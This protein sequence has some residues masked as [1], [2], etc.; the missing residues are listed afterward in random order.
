MENFLNNGTV[1][2]HG[3]M[4]HG[5]ED[6]MRGFNRTYQNT[7]LRVGMIAASYA[8]SDD[9]NIS[10]LTTEYDVTVI[11]QDSNQG[12]ASVTYKNCM[13][14]EG[15]GSIADFFERNLRVRS[16]SGQQNPSI[17]FK[18]QDGAIVLI[19]CL[20]AMT[21]KAIIV[22]SLTHPDRQTTLTDTDPRLAGTYNGVAVLVNPDGSCS[23]TFNGA[24]DNNGDPTDT[25][26]GV[27][28]L[29]I[30]TDGS[31]EF[32]HDAIDILA[33]RNGTLNITTKVDCNIQ[34]QG[35]MVIGCVDADVTASG[36]LNAN[37]SGKGNIQTG[38]DA[39]LQI[40]GNCNLTASG[41]VVVKGSEIDLNNPEGMVLTNVTD[42]VVDLITGVPTMGVPKVKAG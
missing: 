3:L 39:T 21:E 24:T 17:D 33:N 20:D 22:S 12:I 15:F 7:A 25:S 27:T 2:Q 28:T 4:S 13:S 1:L 10:K 36:D 5:P 9:K 34:A 23:L 8:V 31:F 29:Q 26:Q 14:A 19:M 32:M 6:F 37:I 16:A 40:G 41:N 11:Q 30:K 35:N 42:P 38:A 18:G